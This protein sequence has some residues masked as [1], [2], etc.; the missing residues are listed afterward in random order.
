MQT[1]AQRLTHLREMGGLSRF[2]LHVLAKISRG[3]PGHI[4]TGRVQDVGV[5]VLGRIADVFGVSID[6][7]A[8][9]DGK[10]PTARSVADAVKSARRREARGAAKAAS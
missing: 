5:A 7:L 2:E 8:R 4:E 10:A 9:G 3:F 6:W 1:M